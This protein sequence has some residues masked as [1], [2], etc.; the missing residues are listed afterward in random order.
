MVQKIPGRIKTKNK[1]EE[2]SKNN[3]QEGY[4]KKEKIIFI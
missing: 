4:S 3:P 2:K 1:A